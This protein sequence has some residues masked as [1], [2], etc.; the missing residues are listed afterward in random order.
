MYPNQTIGLTAARALIFAQPEILRGSAGDKLKSAYHVLRDKTLS[1]AKAE[2]I[3]L[4]SDINSDAKLRAFAN[5]ID[6]SGREFISEYYFLMIDLV[7]AL[8]CH[9]WADR[10]DPSSW[11]KLRWFFESDLS[12]RHAAR[13]ENDQIVRVLILSKPV[14][15]TT[16]DAQIVPSHVTVKLM[17]SSGF[18]IVPEDIYFEIPI[19]YGLFQIYR[20]PDC[21]SNLAE[22]SVGREYYAVINRDF[23]QPLFR[24]TIIGD[25]YT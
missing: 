3:G 17:E 7:D 13:D 14:D 23:G 25:S 11:I 18:E 8:N 9:L 6:F 5:T 21:L 19:G 1:H 4:E 15:T 10:R 12:L 2:L 16:R 24:Y 22:L 20:D